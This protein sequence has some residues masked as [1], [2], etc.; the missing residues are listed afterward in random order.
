[1]M[2]HIIASSLPPPKARHRGDH[3]LAHLADGLPVAGDEAARVGLHV[4]QRGHGGDVGARRKGLLAAG[5]DDAAD[6]F[7]GIEGQQRRAQL[8]HQLPVQGIELLGPVQGDQAGLAR[9]LAPDLG[10]DAFIAHGVFLSVLLGNDERT[11]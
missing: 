8:V 7:V 5:D 9:A 6:A 2:S 10:Q 3:R 11:I 1:M 4:A